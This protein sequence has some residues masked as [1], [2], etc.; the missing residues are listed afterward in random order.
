MNIIIAAK[1]KVGVDIV[2]LACIVSKPHAL[3]R[4][5]RACPQKNIKNLPSSD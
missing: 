1:F 3:V 4:G 2:G 5:S